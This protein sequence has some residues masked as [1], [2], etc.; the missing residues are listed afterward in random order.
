MKKYIYSI[1]A[2]LALA[3]SGY[4]VHQSDVLKA[5]AETFDKPVVTAPVE[6]APTAAPVESPV[7][8]EPVTAIQ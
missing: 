5:K 1:L 8:K 6:V 7:S 4:F 3:I 2:A